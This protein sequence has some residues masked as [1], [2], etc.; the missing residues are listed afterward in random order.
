MVPAGALHMEN[1]SYYVLV[2]EE[3]ETVLGTQYQIR[4]VDVQV[5]EKSDTYAALAEGALSSEA[6]VVTDADRY[7]EAGSRVRLREP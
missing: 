3:E 7:V 4:R 1:G 2:V 5:S 6:Q